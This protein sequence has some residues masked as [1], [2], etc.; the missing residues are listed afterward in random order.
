MTNW[1]RTIRYPRD[2]YDRAI[3]PDHDVPPLNIGWAVWRGRVTAHEAPY[4]GNTV[5]VGE[6]DHRRCVGG[7]YPSGDWWL[8]CGRCRG[9]FP[10]GSVLVEQVGAG[11]G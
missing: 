11:A 2:E 9:A 1:R 7:W 6:A 8:H 4:A 3:V 10:D 5:T